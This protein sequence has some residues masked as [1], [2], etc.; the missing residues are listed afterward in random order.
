MSPNFIKKTMWRKSADYW[1]NIPLFWK[2][3][4]L[5]KFARIEIKYILR[6]NRGKLPESS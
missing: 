4:G 2:F 5:S 1:E 6:L 3:V